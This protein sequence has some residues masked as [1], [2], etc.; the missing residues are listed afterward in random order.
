MFIWR[1]HLTRHLVFY[2]LNLHHIKIRK[3][4]R[5]G[6]L[7]P[8]LCYKGLQFSPWTGC[9]FLFS[10]RKSTSLW[11]GYFSKEWNSFKFCLWST[12]TSRL[13]CDHSPMNELGNGYCPLYPAEDCH[14][15]WHLD[16]Y[17][18]EPE[19]PW[20]SAQISHP[21][22]PWDHMCLLFYTPMIRVMFYVAVDSKSSHCVLPR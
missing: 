7:L 8:K 18:L 6:M 4:K 22:K 3:Q 9:I 17:L 14:S 12:D 2:L 15:G 20:S 5:S 16:Y 11:R 21:Q 13:C 1:L 10:L 19:N